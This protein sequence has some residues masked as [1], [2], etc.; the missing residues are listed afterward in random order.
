MRG[1][2]I[3]DFRGLALCCLSLCCLARGGHFKFTTLEFR[4]WGVGMQPP[5]GLEGYEQC[6]ID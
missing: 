6:V 5:Y 2:G 3:F 4:V 1:A